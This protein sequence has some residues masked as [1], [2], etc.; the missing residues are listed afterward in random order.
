V[1]TQ[2][3]VV[4]YDRGVGLSD[5]VVTVPSICSAAGAGE[6][7]VSQPARE[8]RSRPA[9]TAAAG[10]HPA[11]PAPG[12]GIARLARGAPSDAGRRSRARLDQ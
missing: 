4:T 12:R 3:R 10:D 2:G 1:A 8:Q 9:P 5:P 6:V 11:R 7:L